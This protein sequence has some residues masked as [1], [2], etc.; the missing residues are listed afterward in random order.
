MRRFIL[1]TMLF[2]LLGQTGNAWWECG[3]HIIAL[4]AYEQLS[5][6]EQKE[7]YRLLKSH[8][9]FE[10]DFV[11]PLKTSNVMRWQIGHAGYWPD[12]ARKVEKYHRSSWHYQLGSTLDIGNVNSPS[13]PGPLPN[14]ATLETH[15]LHVCQ[16]IALCRRVLKD[17]SRSDADWSIAICWLA[18]CIGDIHQPCHAGSLYVAGV[19]PDGDR[20]G[21]RVATVQRNNL[22]ALWD[23]LLGEKFDQGDIAR[24]MQQIK[25]DKKGWATATAAAK[26]LDPDKWV[27][28]SRDIAKRM[29]YT[30]EVLNPIAA[31]RRSGTDVVETISLSDEY[32]K[33]A[34]KISRQ[35]VAFAAHRLAAVWR[36]CLEE[37]H[38]KA[39]LN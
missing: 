3:H 30:Y 1:S 4:L 29:T 23:S 39:Q 34:G 21:N 26:N 22:H 28:E 13:D 14:N 36:L 10:L 31:A 16:A 9:R 25:S 24:R 6:P 17:S 35:R 2:L 27:A 8:P 19:F 11:P 33:T 38:Q 7:L 37:Q 15:K 20:G 18:H 5:P 32:L 12:V